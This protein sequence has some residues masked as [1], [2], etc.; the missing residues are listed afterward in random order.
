MHPSTLRACY[1]DQLWYIA[2]CAP[3]M[4]YHFLHFGS[5]SESLIS[6]STDDSELQLET[7]HKQRMCYHS[8]WKHTTF[9]LTNQHRNKFDVLCTHTH[10][11]TQPCDHVPFPRTWRHVAFPLFFHT[12]WQWATAAN[13]QN[14]T[15][16]GGYKAL[17]CIFSHI[18]SL[19]RQTARLTSTQLQPVRHRCCH[20]G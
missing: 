19:E 13:T 1:G 3:D 6:S 10:T 18:H 12:H 20:S 5:E 2:R 7:S 15:V 8:S 17:I 16:A 11:H 14:I 9:K 4:A